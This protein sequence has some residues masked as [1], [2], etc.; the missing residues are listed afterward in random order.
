M[1]RQTWLT[2][3]LLSAISTIS[4]FAQGTISFNN[5]TD[6][7]GA[8]VVDGMVGAEGT[9][10]LTGGSTTLIFGRDIGGINIGSGNP[11]Y[12]TGGSGSGA[13]VSGTASNIRARSFEG[14]GYF[15]SSSDSVDSAFALQLG[16]GVDPRMASSFQGQAV[17]E[18]STVALAVTGLLLFAGMLRKRSR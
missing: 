17:P 1:K 16:N 4:T 5:R 18:P 3:A 6:A 13:T 2:I 9:I 11:N 15:N 12:A 8:L 7:L 14:S 10:I